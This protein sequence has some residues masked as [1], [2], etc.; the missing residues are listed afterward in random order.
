MAAFA[1][2][3]KSAGT[4]E[5][6]ALSILADVYVFLYIQKFFSPV[7]R[8]ISL[9][10]VIFPEKREPKRYSK[11]FLVI[12]TSFIR[13]KVYQFENKTDALIIFIGD[14]SRSCVKK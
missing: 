3:I 7:E 8:I 11:V 4:T 12:A 10:F 14:R 1:R 9:E 5:L 2:K 6:C 13:D